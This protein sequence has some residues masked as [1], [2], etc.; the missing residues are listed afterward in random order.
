MPASADVV[1]A[2]DKDILEAVRI[3]PRTQAQLL[4]VMPPEDGLTD[5]QRET[6]LRSALTRLRVKKHVA[7]I[8]DLWTLETSG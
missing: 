4:N 1:A 5:E 2:R 3:R 6:A 7:L 8:G